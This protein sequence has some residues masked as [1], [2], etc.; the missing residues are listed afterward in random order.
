MQLSKI[1]GNTY[2]IPAPTN[3]GVFQFKDRYTLLID[4]G[5]NNQQARKIAITLQANNLNVKYI[6][7]THNHIDHAGGNLFFQEN[8]PGSFFY[9]SEDEKLFL[10][11]GYWFPMYLYGG[12]P[13]K[14]LSRHFLR[15]KQLRVDEILYPGTNKINDERLEIIG[16]PGHA[17]GQI[18]IGTRDRVCFLGDALFSQEVIAKYSF[19]FLFDVE[20]QLQTYQKVLACDYDFFVLGHARQ[21]YKRVEMEELV[22]FNQDNLVYYLDLIRDILTQP[23]TREEILEEICILADLQLDFKEYFFSLSTA[24]AMV[25]YLYDNGELDYQLENGKLYYYRK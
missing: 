15:G 17:R 13:P 24:G 8:Y 23:H 2:Y 6:I 5:D 25:T 3:I 14:E 1:N 20:A 18:G 12:N 22:Q 9:S 10:E 7:N 21:P 19:P 16:M 4:T 11:N